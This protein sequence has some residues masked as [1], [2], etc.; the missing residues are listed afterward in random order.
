MRTRLFT[1]LL[2]FAVFACGGESAD[3]A[4]QAD[5][6]AA[7][8]E[9]QD[10]ASTG[11]AE[12]LDEMVSGWQTHYNMGHGSMVADFFN[13]DAIMWSGGQGMA[14][15]KEAITAMLQG[16]IDANHP[17]ISI[18]TD[19]EIIE[20]DQALARGTY[21]T[22]GTTDGGE[23]ISSSGYWISLSNWNGD[24]WKI[25]GLISNVDSEQDLSGFV[26]AEM[27]APNESASMVADNAAYTVTHFNMGHA[28]M[29]ASRYAEDAIAMFS[30][31]PA[32]EGRAAIEAYMT[33]L[34]DQGAQLAVTPW[35]AAPVGDDL[36][37][38]I[39]TFTLTIGDQVSM[40]H[41]AN[42]LRKMDD[43]TMQTVWV[44]TAVHPAGM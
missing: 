2:A 19:E 31:A 41:F 12:A 33:G 16:G 27:P 34:T 8:T 14:F 43:G 26:H 1:P 30:G 28:G 25:R 36:V 13:D 6:T 38:S 44:L 40:G 7:A 11:T 29:V 39:G 10:F 9:T 3:T 37:T 21:T 32:L 20:G 17:Q 22:N 24:A 23:A 35:A 15:G 18:T 42:L 5:A 4:D